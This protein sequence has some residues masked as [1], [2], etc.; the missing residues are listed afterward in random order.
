[1]AIWYHTKSPL[2]LYNPNI[3]FCLITESSFFD[4]YVFSSDL[5]SDGSLLKLFGFMG[6]HSVKDFRSHKK[7]PSRLH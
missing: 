1:M 5:V 6:K 2:I 7:K 4:K 3:F